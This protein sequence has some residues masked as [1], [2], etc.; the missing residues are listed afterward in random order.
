M[1][2]F[3][4]AKE[5]KKKRKRGK[6]KNRGRGHISDKLA[7]AEHAVLARAARFA[8]L[9]GAAANRSITNYVLFSKKM[10][11][12]LME[13]VSEICDA[14]SVQ[15]CELIG[16]GMPDDFIAMAESLGL[17][18]EA[19]RDKMAKK[20]AERIAAREASGESPDLRKRSRKPPQ[21][22]SDAQPSTQ[23]SSH[24]PKQTSHNHQHAKAAKHG[25]KAHAPPKSRTQT[26][27]GEPHHRAP[28]PA[29]AAAQGL[30][31]A[32]KAQPPGRKKA[33]ATVPSSVA[34]DPPEAPPLA[35]EAGGPG[36][37]AQGT[38]NTP[39][40]PRVVHAETAP[41]EP[42]SARPQGA[43]GDPQEMPSSQP[44]CA[45]EEIGRTVQKE[46]AIRSREAGAQRAQVMDQNLPT[47]SSPGRRAGET[48]VRPAPSSPENAGAPEAQGEVAAQ[49]V[50]GQSGST[51]GA[52]TLGSS[53]VGAEAQARTPSAPGMAPG[54]TATGAATSPATAKSA[55]AKNA[56]GPIQQS[57][58]PG[59][60]PARAA[61]GTST[62]SM[63]AGAS[64]SARAQTKS[65]SSVGGGTPQKATSGRLASPASV[66]AHAQSPENPSAPGVDPG[67]AAPGAKTT[68][69]R[70]AEAVQS[71]GK[72]SS[73]PGGAMPGRAAGGAQGS[74]SSMAGASAQRSADCIPVTVMP[75]SAQASSSQPAAG[76]AQSPPDGAVEG[77][78]SE[79]GTSAARAA[80]SLKAKTPKKT[81]TLDTNHPS[82]H[83][84]GKKKEFSSFKKS[85]HRY[86][87]SQPQAC[88][89][90]AGSD[91]SSDTS[92]PESTDQQMDNDFSSFLPSHQDGETSWNLSSGGTRERIGR[93]LRQARE[94]DPSPSSRDSS[95]ERSD[96][97]AGKVRSSGISNSARQRIFTKSL[98]TKTS[99]PKDFFGSLKQNQGFSSSVRPSEQELR[100]SARVAGM[101]PQIPGPAQTGSQS[102]PARE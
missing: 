64:P 13:A 34:A 61:H 95:S 74:S 31:R 75:V 82:P 1:L 49:T 71:Q 80:E 62:K 42:H 91:A 15:I 101:L 63:S 46:L 59:L 86:N 70:D 2:N 17:K 4:E 66:G 8:G 40:Q 102:A 54:G 3:A 68:R 47:A 12:S 79:N 19:I 26:S 60:A 50:S 53:R 56:Q 16:A 76:G 84:F 5:V 88:N 83:V 98:T 45:E 87:K 28:Q 89:A 78:S 92:A 48:A 38:Q 20:T 96:G 24:P 85:P 52:A 25:K 67:A 57:S 65:L 37:I 36:A 41:G 97:A 39:S 29:P 69:D 30:A 32:G 99:T 90:E 33:A 18:L 51:P 77:A 14:C 93:K 100:R 43:G 6:R 72:S 11:V 73:Q 44:S 7:L 9:E 23:T 10:P 81:H 58:L 21:T 94:V 35:A 55:G 22:H 27:Q